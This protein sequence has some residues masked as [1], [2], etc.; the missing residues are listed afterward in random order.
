ME[1]NT[2]FR[3]QKFCDLVRDTLQQVCNSIY[4]EIATVG[5]SRSKYNH[6]LKQKIEGVLQ[7]QRGKA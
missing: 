2:R 5:W 1:L 7:Q 6:T 3:L 4:T